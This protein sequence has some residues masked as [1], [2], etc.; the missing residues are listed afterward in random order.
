MNGQGERLTAEDVLALAPDAASR[1]AGAGLAVPG[2]WSGTGARGGAV[3]GECEGSGS[4]PYRTVA[5][6]TGEGGPGFQCTCP[7][8]KSPCKHALGLLLLWASG[9]EAVPGVPEGAGAPPGWAGS[10]LERRRTRSGAVPGPSG[11]TQRKAADGEAARKRAERRARRI[12]SGA[13]ELEQRLVDLL[14]GGLA[15]ASGDGAYGQWEET[16]ARMVDAQAPGLAARVRE[17]ASAAGPG[18]G[19]E[20]ASRLLEECAL[21]HTLNQ[22]YMR[23]DRLPEPLAATV[24]T[25][26]GLTTDAASL[27][28]TGP[29]V[30]DHWLVLAQRDADDG[31]LITRRIWLYGRGTRRMALL[32]SYGAAGRAPEL[33]LPVGLSLDADLAFHPSARPLR[34][35]LGTRH[36]TPVPC[37]AAPPG[38]DAAAALRAYGEALR[39]DPWLDSWPVVLSP[40][41]PLPDAR[42]GWQLADARGEA[43]LPVDPRCVDRTGLWQLAAIS[44]GSPVTVFAE[45]GHRGVVPLA[46]WGPEPVAL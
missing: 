1:R 18:A 27:L 17:L 3:W 42:L 7:S 43:A 13:A 16:A 26:V 33:S 15:A 19:A 34:A 40:V 9:E 20:R 32:L 2:S 6:L 41:I 38:G 35:S 46:A 25:R 29:L 45:C 39:D 21:L 11:S 8:R 5:D 36:A 44:G 28:A 4:T 24:R 14:R 30:R 22:G 37:T 31:R 23:L 10:W 12:A